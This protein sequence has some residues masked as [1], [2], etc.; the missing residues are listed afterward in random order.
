MS[1]EI[2]PELQ[3]FV[4]VGKQIVARVA[5]ILPNISKTTKSTESNTKIDAFSAK[6]AED[7]GQAA[8][9]PLIQ[10]A[11]SLPMLEILV[12]K[13]IVDP[14][15]Y[16]DKVDALL[17]AFDEVFGTML[18]AL[19][20]RFDREVRFRIDTKSGDT[21]EEVAKVPLNDPE[22]RKFVSMGSVLGNMRVWDLKNDCQVNTL[23]E[24]AALVKKEA[25]E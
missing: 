1:T 4:D 20:A 8:V 13:G 15:E 22:L 10:T 24:Y 14:D 6:Y 23:E 18:T 16:Y 9:S 21:W 11:V 7:L 3:E 25:M 19:K 2:P 17:D 12:K 5:E